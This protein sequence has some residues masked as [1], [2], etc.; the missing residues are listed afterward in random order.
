MTSRGANGGTARGHTFIGAR[1]GRRS[2]G[3]DPLFKQILVLLLLVILVF[4]VLVV[5]LVARA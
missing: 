2:R 4:A 5:Y 3:M 1:G